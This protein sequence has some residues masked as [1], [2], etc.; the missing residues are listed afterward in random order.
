MQKPRGALMDVTLDEE[1]LFILYGGRRAFATRIMNAVS[2]AIARGT[3]YAAA[4]AAERLAYALHGRHSDQIPDLQRPSTY[5]YR[6]GPPHRHEFARAARGVG[7][8]AGELG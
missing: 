3:G 7:G 8:R 6:R 5:V 4:V 2:C 1:R